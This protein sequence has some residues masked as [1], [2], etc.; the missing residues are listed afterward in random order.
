LGVLGVQGSEFGES[1]ATDWARSE[2]EET[3]TS[4]STSIGISVDPDADVELEA[5]DVIGRLV[6]AVARFVT[7]MEDGVEVE[8]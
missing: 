2:E 7:G 8:I 6:A 3:V 1:S 5:L 4:T